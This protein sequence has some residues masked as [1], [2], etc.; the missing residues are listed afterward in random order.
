MS[1]E[2]AITNES[3]NFLK[4]SADFLNIVLNNISSCILILDKNIRL[5]AFNDVLK[6]VFSN[7]KDENLLYV[8]CGEAIGCAYQIEEN[9]NCGDTSRCKECELRIAALTSYTEDKAIFKDHIVRPFFDNNGEKVEKHLQFSTRLFNYQ[10]EKYIIMIVDDITKFVDNSK[11]L[12][13]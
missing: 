10:D 3:F 8:R 9:K 11:P 13:S 7:K 1:A 5:R 4:G 2:V 6:T 12:A